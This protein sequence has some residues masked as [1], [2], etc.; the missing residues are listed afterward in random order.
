[1]NKL[2]GILAGFFRRLSDICEGMRKPAYPI[3]LDIQDAISRRKARLRD[4]LSH[5]ELAE[6]ERKELAELAA[7]FEG[8]VIFLDEPI[9][10]AKEGL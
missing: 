8:E 6:A 2:L 10:T 4:L 5:E 3:A 1:M 7:Q 9:H